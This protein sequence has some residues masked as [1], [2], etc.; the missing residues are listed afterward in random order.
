MEIKI[1]DYYR[2]SY[3]EKYEKELF[4]PYHCFDGILFVKQKND[5]SLYLVDTYW[6]SG[7]RSFTLEQALEQ[8]ILTFICNIN[9]VEPCV[10]SEKR[11]Y[12]SDDFFNLSSQHGCY[13]RYFKRKNA[14][15]SSELMEEELKKLIDERKHEIEYA[16]YDIKRYVEYIDRLKSGDNS[17]WF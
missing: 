3:N 17:F 13:E 9:D 8:G 14:A 2:F 15:R 12:N 6:S 11:Y 10:K 5:G 16:E 7:G 1:G 4:M